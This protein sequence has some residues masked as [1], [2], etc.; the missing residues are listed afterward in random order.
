MIISFKHKY[1][2]VGLPNSGS[3]AISKELIENYDGV[4]IENKHT[5]IPYFKWKHKV[6][7]NDYFIFGVYR[8]PIDIC[9]SQF[10]KIKVNA[11]GAYTNS[12][13]Q[14]RNGGF[15]SKRDYAFFLEVQNSNLSFEQYLTKKYF[16]IPYDN[17]FSINKKYF[18]FIINFNSLNEGFKEAL[19]LC[20]L[21]VVRD[22]PLY[23]KTIVK[24][25]CPELNFK[26]ISNIFSP[27]YFKYNKTILFDSELKLNY[28]S[29]FKFQL[30]H[31]F[32][33][34][35]TF[36]KDKNRNHFMDSY[37]GNR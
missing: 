18:N 2:F 11:K 17:L 28:I 21:K 35:K 6:D 34:I 30:F 37:F 19:S 33:F 1:I 3:S 23:N 8:D 15:V 4:S 12:L 25:S 7:L 22:L 9:F 5:S 29:L 13:L 26:L 20:N 27:F 32:R 10:S 14:K 36:I 31:L 16:F 24:N